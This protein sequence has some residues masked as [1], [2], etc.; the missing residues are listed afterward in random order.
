LTKVGLKTQQEFGMGNL[1]LA[2]WFG[3]NEDAA[4]VILN[5]RN[6]EKD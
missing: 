5:A 1:G 3:G 4:W 6:K 2:N